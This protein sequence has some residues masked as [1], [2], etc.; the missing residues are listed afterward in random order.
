M[1]HFFYSLVTSAALLF[2][3]MHLHSWW[4][5]SHLNKL[6]KNAKAQSKEV[7]RWNKSLDCRRARGFVAVSLAGVRRMRFKSKL[8]YT[9]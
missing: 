6:W 3:P 4:L 5:P 9:L 7:R 1:C 8:S 2:V